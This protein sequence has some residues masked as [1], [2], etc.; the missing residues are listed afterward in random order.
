MKGYY[1][2]RLAR[3]APRDSTGI[4]RK[5][6]LGTDLKGARQ[7]LRTLQGDNVREVDF[8]KGKAVRLTF[9]Q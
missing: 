1:L 6:P 7:K 5:V 9:D 4:N 8:D 2:A 3:C